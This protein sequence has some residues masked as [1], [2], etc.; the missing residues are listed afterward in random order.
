MDINFDYCNQWLRHSFSCHNL[1]SIDPISMIFWFSE[2]LERDLSNGT[3]NVHIWEITEFTNFDPK[4]WIIA[5]GPRPKM[6]NYGPNQNRDFNTSFERYFSKLSEN[7]KIVEIGWSELKL[8]LLK[9]AQLHPHLAMLPT[10]IS[11]TLGDREVISTVIA[12]LACSTRQQG[13]SAMGQ[14]GWSGGGGG[15]NK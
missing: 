3:I 8:W 15:I 10:T 14:T 13:L 6:R 5:H 2:S 9:D 11:W 1:N 12:L 4:P 7:Y